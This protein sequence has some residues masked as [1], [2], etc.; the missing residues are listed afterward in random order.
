MASSWV[1]GNG[2]DIMSERPN[3]HPIIERQSVGDAWVV[4][5]ADYEDGETDYVSV[6]YFLGRDGC[7]R[8]YRRADFRW[9]QHEFPDRSSAEEAVA[10]AT[11]LGDACW[12]GTVQMERWGPNDEDFPTPPATKPS[13]EDAE[14]WL[15]VFAKRYQIGYEDLIDGVAYG[16]GGTFGTST[17]PDELECA[18]VKA[19]LR[20]VLGESAEEQDW[21]D[22][23]S[24]FGCAC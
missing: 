21:Q 9:D 16:N 23:I 10:L 22:T 11:L 4:R 7:W 12:Q 1:S 18:D 8:H 17:G 13:R 20:A 2:S 24:N 15:R 6:G 3:L 5:N 19:Y 14:K